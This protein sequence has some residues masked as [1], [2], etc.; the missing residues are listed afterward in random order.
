MTCRVCSW[1]PGRGPGER[2][3]AEQLDGAA[4]GVGCL[5]RG[6][7]V[8]VVVVQEA[9]AA[10]VELLLQVQLQ[11]RH[12]LHLGRDRGLQVTQAINKLMSGLTNVGVT[13][14]LLLLAGGRG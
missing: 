3:G 1:L 11:V 5:H 7:G 13:H 6:E 8:V 10:D 4:A 9:A 12:V 2:L 14:V